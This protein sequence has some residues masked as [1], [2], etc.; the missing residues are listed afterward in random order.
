V[1]WPCIPVGLGGKAEHHLGS[2]VPTQTTSPEVRG[3]A[4]ATFPNK[5]LDGVWLD[6]RGCV[7]GRPL[8]QALLLGWALKLNFPKEARAPRCLLWLMDGQRGLGDTI[9]E[10]GVLQCTH[11]LTHPR[12]SQTGSEYCSPALPTLFIPQW[13]KTKSSYPWSL[14]QLSS[15]PFIIFCTA[16]SSLCLLLLRDRRFVL[17][18]ASLGTGKRFQRFTHSSPLGKR[19]ARELCLPL[20]CCLGY[21]FTKQ[22]IWKLSL[23]HPFS[24]CPMLWLAEKHFLTKGS[25]T[26]MLSGQ[27]LLTQ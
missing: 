21:C 11:I 12:E 16:I 23:R 25:Q 10:V 22:P 24:L 6:H 17:N 8:L 1:S 14:P 15:F 26:N 18:W 3:P 4:T 5:L 13:G 20:L 2:T 9:A 19:Q 7:Q 27:A